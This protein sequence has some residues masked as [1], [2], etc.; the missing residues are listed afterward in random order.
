MGV[1]MLLLGVIAYVIAPVFIG[2]HAVYKA[3]DSPLLSVCVTAGVFIACFTVGA[4]VR[5]FWG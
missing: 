1:L 2:Y 3:T 5:Y 4:V